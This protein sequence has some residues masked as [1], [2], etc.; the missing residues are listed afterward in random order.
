MRRHLALV[1]PVLLVVL[2]TPSQPARAQGIPVF[3]VSNLQQLL[4][5][6]TNTVETLNKLQQQY[7]TILKIS[8]ALGSMDRYRTP[9]I[10]MTSLNTAAFPYGQA[11]LEGMNSGDA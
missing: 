5:I 9:P 7:A 8:Q 3:D 2:L 10:A 1:V 6:T 4:E 11:W